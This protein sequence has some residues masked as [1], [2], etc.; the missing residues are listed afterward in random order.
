MGL[1]VGDIDK[2][3][4][5]NTLTELRNEERIIV[6]E[7]LED[8]YVLKY[9]DQQQVGGASMKQKM[10]AESVMPL[11]QLFPSSNVFYIVYGMVVEDTKLKI[12]A[13][14]K[15]IQLDRESPIS[16]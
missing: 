3:G 14:L 15:C 7:C 12:A 4:F 9:M 1:E 10:S 8:Y 6:K 5:Y 11:I 2:D 16:V 13:F